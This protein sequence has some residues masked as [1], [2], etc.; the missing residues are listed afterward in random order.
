M[1]VR[2]NNAVMLEVGRER[3]VPVV[4]T[5]ELAWHPEWFVDECHATAEGHAERARTIFERLEECLAEH[6]GE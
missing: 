1:R 3:D 6:G 5:A 2:D 4:D